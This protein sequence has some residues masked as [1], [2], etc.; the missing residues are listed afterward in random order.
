MHRHSLII[1][2]LVLLLPMIAYDLATKRIPSRL[3][4]EQ[5]PKS[6]SGI[7]PVDGFGSDADSDGVE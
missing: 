2:S 1:L 7:I 5:A 6:E 4:F 3:Q